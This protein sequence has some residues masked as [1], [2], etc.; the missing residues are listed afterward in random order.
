MTST[1]KK[2]LFS[3][4]SIALGIYAQ[5]HKMHI[6]G[7]IFDPILAAC[8]APHESVEAFAK[9]TGYQ[10]YEPVAGMG[11]FT[12]IVCVVTQFMHQL[13]NI[14]PEGYITWGLAVVGVFPMSLIMTIEGGRNGAKGPLRYPILMGIFHQLLGMSVSVPLLW[15][16]AYIWGRGE[17]PVTSTRLYLSVATAIPACIFSTLVFLID[18]DSYLWRLSA[19]I[20]GGPMLAVVSGFAVYFDKP[21]NKESKTAIAKHVKTSKEMYGFMTVMCLICWAALLRLTFASYGFD[22]KGIWSAIFADADAGVAF[23][24]IDYILIFIAV[25]FGFLAYQCWATAI[26][27]LLALPLLGP[28]ALTIAAERLEVAESEKMLEK[29]KVA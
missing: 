18:T 19:G 23:L 26:K 15:V 25:I 10:P 12:P 16:P 4:A 6:T 11:I 7:P 29:A 3:L 9:A 5:I 1:T 14:Y 2:V 17:G 24:T 20:L 22:L 13:R 8:S 27:T 21:P 28:A